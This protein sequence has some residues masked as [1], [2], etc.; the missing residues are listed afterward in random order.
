M[1]S[2]DFRRARE[3]YL[4]STG[5]EHLIPIDRRM[6]DDD[7]ERIEPAKQELRGAAYMDLLAKR[8]KV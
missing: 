4:R 2:E 8:E 1:P 5:R 6:F 3:A 7:G